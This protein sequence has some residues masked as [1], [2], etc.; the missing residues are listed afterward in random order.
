M[1]ISSFR[2]AILSYKIRWHV[3]L[4]HF[5]ISFFLVAFMFQILH[6]F[7][8]PS[9][10]EISTNVA[11]AAGTIM[12]IPTTLSG[13]FSWKKYYKA[14]RVMLFQRKI[15]TAFVMLG[16]S[17]VLLSWRSFV[18]GFFEEAPTNPEH[19]IYLAGNTLLIFGAVIEGYYGGRLN[20]NK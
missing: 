1:S 11:L 3:L 2:Q 8:Q 10:F 17:I 16:L 4:V 15:T 12:M 20:H 19:W 14:A 9:C 13:W 6:L 5:P 7:T 18:L